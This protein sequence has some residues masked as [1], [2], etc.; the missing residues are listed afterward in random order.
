MDALTQRQYDGQRCSDLQLCQ[1][2]QLEEALVAEHVLS[3]QMQPEHVRWVYKNGLLRQQEKNFTLSNP[4]AIEPI[5]S[6]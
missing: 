2:H 4:L 3:G 6:C 1:P 5:S